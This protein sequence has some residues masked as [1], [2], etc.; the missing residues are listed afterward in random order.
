MLIHFSSSNRDATIMPNSLQTPPDRGL[1]LILVTSIL[2]FLTVIVVALRLFARIVI[3]RIPG[4]DD[5]CALAATIVA[6]GA[7]VSMC[8]G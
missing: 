3:L 1:A 8:L 5:W 6:I 4:L 7:V 2:T